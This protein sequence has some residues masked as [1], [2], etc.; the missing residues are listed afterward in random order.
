MTV[1]AGGK[2]LEEFTL[3]DLVTQAN[4]ALERA[5]QPASD[6]RVTERLDARTVR[7]Y[8]TL[9]L[10]P[11]PHRYEGRQ[12]RYSRVHLIHLLVIKKL[13][14]QGLTLSQVQRWL[15]G[16]SEEEL[17]TLV[18][19]NATLPS[20]DLA[21]APRQ[22]AHSPPK[23]MLPEEPI[24]KLHAFQLA[25]GV[26]LLLDPASIRNPGQVAHRLRAAIET[27]EMNPDETRPSSN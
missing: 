7:Y 11:K 16:R 9:G 18:D 6:G 20:A 12:A 22:A 24:R 25:P 17:R 15:S 21:E 27:Q 4:G 2:H 19:A 23:L 13:Q 10:V 26:E 5:G 8:S 3:K 1:N 14:A